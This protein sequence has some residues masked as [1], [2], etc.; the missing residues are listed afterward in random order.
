MKIRTILFKILI[1]LLFVYLAWQLIYS[2]NGTVSLFRLSRDKE[3]LALENKAL[4]EQ[5][6]SLEKKVGRMKSKSLD[7]DTLDE[8]AR[9]NLGY[10][11]DDDVIYIE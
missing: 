7:L 11:K 4:E 6:A 8:Q 2:K 1:A 3:K 10:S 9:K 5:K